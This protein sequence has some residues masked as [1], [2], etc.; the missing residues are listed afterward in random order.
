MLSLADYCIITQV[1][2]DITSDIVEI[3]IILVCIFES[4]FSNK[5]LKNLKSIERAYGIG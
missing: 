3:S 1:A 2:Y 5:A 4:I